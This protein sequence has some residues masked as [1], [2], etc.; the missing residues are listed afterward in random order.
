M[1]KKPVQESSLGP[2][3][4]L[5]PPF[6]PLLIHHFASVRPSV[7]PSVTGPKFRLDK[8]Y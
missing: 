5:G 2:G 6:K 4:F 1:L 3:R 7:R 8:N